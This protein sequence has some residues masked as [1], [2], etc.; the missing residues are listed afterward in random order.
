MS[1]REALAPPLDSFLRRPRGSGTWPLE[2]SAEVRAQDEVAMRTGKGMLDQRFR[3]IRL[4]YARIEL[5]KFR[6]RQGGP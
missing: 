4:R 5:A 2:R 1:D 3:A 6:F